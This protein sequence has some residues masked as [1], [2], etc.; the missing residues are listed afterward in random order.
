MKELFSMDMKNY[1]SDYKTS[2]NR[3]S[4]RGINIVNNKIAVVYSKKYD[5]YKIPGGGINKDENDLETLKREIEEETG[6]IVIDETVKEWGHVLVKEKGCF[7]DLFIQD[8]LYYFF[9][10]KDKLGNLNLDEYEMDE[11][12]ELKYVSAEEFLDKNVNSNHNGYTDLTLI[13]REIETIKLL[14]REHYLS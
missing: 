12:Y 9:D 14:I 13:K 7:E 11:Q 2:F 6:L 10:C 8:N 1:I 3:P 4:V 5:L